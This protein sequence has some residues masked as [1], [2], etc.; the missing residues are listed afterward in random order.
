MFR[1][2]LLVFLGVA[3][4]VLVP[5]TAYLARTLPDHFSTGQWRVAWVGFDAVLVCCFGLAAWLGYRRRRAAVALLVATAA[6]LCCDAWFDVV[7]DWTSS[8]RWTSIVLAAGIEVP[9]AVLL[10]LRARAMVVGG[11]RRRTLTIDDIELQQNPECVAVMSVLSA[12]PATVEHLATTLERPAT[13]VHS[14]LHQLARTGHVRRVRGGRWSLVPQDLR[15]PEVDGLDQADRTV[16]TTYL[17]AKY[18]TE[19]R[20]LTWAAGHRQEF[21]AW[22]KAHRSRLHLT[23]SELAA[24]DAEYAEL[25]ARYCLLRRHPTAD[26]REV[27]VRW[28]AF[29]SP[30][31]APEAVNSIRASDG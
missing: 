3:A 4:V 18:D 24:F 30:D 14:V 1:R 19:L 22:G 8:D 31:P 6:L 13:T 9:I 2:M 17:D 15:E 10:V 11:M 27:A 16:V 12:A 26:T 5:W 28:Y 7:L 25:L 20:L 23:E 21:G 29:P